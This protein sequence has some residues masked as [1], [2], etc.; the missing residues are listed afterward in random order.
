VKQ[1]RVIGP[2]EHLPDA[3]R[4]SQRSVNLYL[5][6]G[7]G[8][9]EDRELM[10]VSAPGLEVFHT[11]ADDI[12]GSINADGRWYVVAGTTL[13]ERVG[14]AFVARGTVSGSGEVS[15]KAGRDQVVIADEQNGFV[16]SEIA[17]A[18]SQIADADWRGTVAVDWMDGYFIFADP[19]TDQFYISAIDDGAD[20]DAL[21]FSSADSQP[22]N[23]VTLR[24]HK[25]QLY[26]FGSRSTELWVNSGGADF[27]FARYN[28]TPIDIGVV[29]KR[30][31]T[32][33][34]DALFFVGQDETGAGF[35][36]E[37]DAYQPRRISTIAVETALAGSTLVDARMWTYKVAGA[38][39]VAIS[40]PGMATTW[41]FDLATR[42]WHERGERSGES[43]APLRIRDVTMFSGSHYGYSGAVVY[44]LTGATIPGAEL[45]RERTFPHLV[46]PSLE[47]LS[48]HALEIACRTGAGGLV[49]LEISNDGGLTFGPP[50]VRSMGATGRYMERIRWMPLGTAMDRVFRIRCSSDADFAIYS[51]ALS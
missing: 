44:E 25:R 45:L 10:L 12:R 29:G 3:R 6:K 40:A 27:P 22:D 26:L 36:F 19:S 32:K 2:S 33:T 21:D 1:P 30:A 42:Q 8:L 11:F 47:P 17:N 31:I 51:G 50:L 24:V 23:I 38:E 13:Y 41:V 16:Y 34:P 9:G 28:A 49:T 37:L 46:H 15:M 18:I 7:E 20:L 4:A 5:S 43:W 14:A 48:Y 35:V 39:F